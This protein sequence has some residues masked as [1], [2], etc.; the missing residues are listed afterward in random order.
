MLFRAH[1]GGF[2]VGCCIS[3]TRKTLT[4]IPFVRPFI[5]YM[6]L[7]LS[8]PPLSLAAALNSSNPTPL[9]LKLQT[10]NASPQ[11]SSQ[12]HQTLDSNP[13]TPKP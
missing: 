9:T 11:S 6:R 3:S 8:G 13:E 1:L 7:S 4:C 5:P 10:S 12:Q 2:W